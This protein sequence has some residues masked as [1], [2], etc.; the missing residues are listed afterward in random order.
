[1]CVGCD[2]AARECPPPHLL[3]ASF[4]PRSHRRTSVITRARSRRP[5]KRNTSWPLQTME[6]AGG[7]VFQGRFMSTGWPASPASNFNDE[8]DEIW[9]VLSRGSSALTFEIKCSSRR[10]KMTT[11]S[12][13]PQIQ[14]INKWFT[15]NNKLRRSADNPFVHW[16]PARII[17]MK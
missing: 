6:T 10:V 16:H 5:Q 14:I 8:H 1:M 7:S 13:R 12:S 17:S 15:G 9:S 2:P 4:L 11:R 3:P